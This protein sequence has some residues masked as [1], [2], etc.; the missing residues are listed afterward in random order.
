MGE[1]TPDGADEL[2]LLVAGFMLLVGPFISSV[3]AAFHPI[4]WIG[5]AL[6][7]IVIGA[8]KGSSG[9]R[10]EAR[11]RHGRTAVTAVPGSPPTAP[12][13]TTAASRSRRSPARSGHHRRITN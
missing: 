11:T 2:A 12:T 7:M 8:T 6:A 4:L 10:P 5:T 1:T 3:L 13:V 9:E